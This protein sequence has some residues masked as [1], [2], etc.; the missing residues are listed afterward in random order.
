MV[1]LPFF[2]QSK[3]WNEINI[4]NYVFNDWIKCLKVSSLRK[5]KH[6][7]RCK[8]NLTNDYEVFI[9]DHV[10]W[11]FKGIYTAVTIDN[12]SY[13][14]FYAKRKLFIFQ[15]IVLKKMLTTKLKIKLTNHFY[16]H[17]CLIDNFCIVNAC[18]FYDNFNYV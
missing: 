15:E 11:Y 16:N 4:L 3:N 1:L 13:L 10:I 5:I 7:P 2:K 14:I 17:I 9:A 18:I 12:D 6:F 8:T